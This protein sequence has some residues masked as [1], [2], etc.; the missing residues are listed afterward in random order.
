MSMNN[1]ANVKITPDQCLRFPFIRAAFGIGA[2]LMLGLLPAGHVYADTTIPSSSNSIVLQTLNPNDS[3]FTA[4]AGTVIT[5]SGAGYGISGNNSKDWQLTN[6]G[7][8]TGTLGGV[9][10]GSATA[11]G[12]RLDN[13]GVIKGANFDLDAGVLMPNGGTIYNHAGALISSDQYYGILDGAVALTIINDGDISGASTPIRLGLGGSVTQGSTGRLLGINTPGLLIDNGAYTVN[14]AGLISSTGAPALLMRGASTGT[15]TNSGTISG[16]FGAFLQSS[17]GGS[18][19]NTGTITGTSG[20]AI[21]ITGSNYQLTLD[22]GSTINGA[23][24]ST[25]SN[26]SLILQGSNTASS[27]YTGFAS[28]RVQGGGSWIVIGNL[29]AAAVTVTGNSVLQ[30]GNN[31]GNGNLSGNVQVDAGSL[32]KFN[33]PSNGTFANVISG[34]GGVVQMT[35][36]AVPTTLTG[37]NTYTGSTTIE[38]G[39]VLNIGNGGTSGSIVGNVVD[40]GGDLRFN[41]AD[42]VIYG[43]AISGVGRVYQDGAGKL[44][45]TGDSGLTAGY[46]VINAGTLQIGNGGASGSF[47]GLIFNDATLAFNRSDALTH[48]GVINGSGAVVQAGVGTTTLT[49]NNAYSGGT[50]V[51]AGTLALSG[52]GKIGSGAA[53]IASGATL[54]VQN[55]G[56]LPYTFNNALSGAGTLRFSPAGASDVFQF[57]A[58]AG[59]AFA[60]TL[61]LDGGS[62]NLTGTNTAALANAILQLQAGRQPGHGQP[63]H[64]K[65]PRPDVERRQPALQPEQPAVGRHR[66]HDQCQYVEHERRHDLHR[67]HSQQHPQPAFAG[68]PDVAGRG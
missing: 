62:L 30:V 12:A 66:R 47:T 4:P 5:D 57:G 14:N 29:S 50:T 6:R 15:V 41:R 63:R 17:A 3:V 10:L 31:T 11:G 46:L 42:D 16:V 7:T 38:S 65:H 49:G 64:A 28:A 25:G 44:I 2:P 8:V 27:N 51:S 48:S 37:N 19:I 21:N 52:N 24:S 9:S 54:Q 1:A 36:G 58:G 43:G 59:T 26:N 35:S 56:T 45:L 22:T 32:L 53:V 20:T 34:S 18:L 55:P 60:G 68:W 33:L 40:N 61:Q 23:V 39:A 13:Y 67:R